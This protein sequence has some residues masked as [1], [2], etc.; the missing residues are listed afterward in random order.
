[1]KKLVLFLVFLGAMGMLMADNSFA[2]IERV[3]TCEQAFDRI[4]ANNDGRISFPEYSM[5]FHRGRYAGTTPSPSG[6]EAFMM[7]GR[8]DRTNTGYIN[9]QEFCAGWTTGT[10][11]GGQ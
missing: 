7:F 2:R 4:D 3:E 11:R 10:G 1:M 5:D 8:M 9:L 6:N